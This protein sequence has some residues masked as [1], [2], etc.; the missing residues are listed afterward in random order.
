MGSNQEGN[1]DIVY[2]YTT[3]E[4]LRGI[5]ENR[6]VWATNVNFLNDISEYHHGVDI[7]REEVEKYELGLESPLAVRFDHTVANWVAKGLIRGNVQQYLNEIDYGRWTFVTSFFDSRGSSEVAVAAD[8]GDDL[9]QWRAYGQRA[10]G[11]SIGFDKSALEAQ[12]SARDYSVTGFFTNADTC[13]YELGGKQER[14]K[15][16]IKSLEPLLPVFLRDDLMEF[17][18]ERALKSY[19][20]AKLGHPQE[21]VKE[22]MDDLARANIFEALEEKVK[23]VFPQFMGELMVQPALMKDQ[24]FVGEKEWRLVTISFDPSR[25]LM[26]ASNSGLIPYMELPL[27]DLDDPTRLGAGLIRRIVVG[28]LGFASKRE[29]D[30]AMFAAQMLLQKNKLPV[31]SAERPDGVIIESSRI[32]FRGDHA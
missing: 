16:I 13:S 26:R 14:V 2:H 29:S 8:A 27:S 1:G 7:I 15:S 31:W 32:P 23:E 4:G 20:R 11:F 9:A 30:N 6:C 5:I 10:A 12:L 17:W 19:F 22:G 25:I 21:T 3:A 24:A 28:P 18:T